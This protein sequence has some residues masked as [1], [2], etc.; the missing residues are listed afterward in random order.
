MLAEFIYAPEVCYT[1]KILFIYFHYTFH[2][3]YNTELSEQKKGARPRHFRQRQF[4]EGWV[5]FSD[6]SVAKALAKMVNNQIVGGKKKNP[7]SEEIWNIKYLPGFKWTHLNEK[8]A[9]DKAVK[10]K[11]LRLEVGQAKKE[12]QSFA[13]NLEFSERIKRKSTKQMKV[14]GEEETG[15]KP[16]KKRKWQ[17]KQKIPE[18]ERQAKPQKDSKRVLGKSAAES[19]SF[20]SNLFTS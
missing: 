5:E 9:Y 8:M 13:E 4:E 19:Q 11:R 7:W 12:A 10:T 15:E 6:K 20:L 1:E 18:A 3:V 14:E 17:F 16:V 2:F